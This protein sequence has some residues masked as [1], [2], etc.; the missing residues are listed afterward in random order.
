MTRNEEL[1]LLQS[2]ELKQ[3]FDEFDK[4]QYIQIQGMQIQTQG[5]FH[6]NT[7]LKKGQ[8]KKYFSGVKSEKFAKICS[9]YAIYR[10]WKQGVKWTNNN[11]NQKEK[12]E[13]VLAAIL[14]AVRSA[15]MG[16]LLGMKT[17]EFIVV[18]LKNEWHG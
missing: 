4:V 10:H 5:K 18:T 15:N 16:K 12:K 14:T 3:A 8:F 9:I 7:V 1:D 11:L 2:A 6:S 13:T 17:K